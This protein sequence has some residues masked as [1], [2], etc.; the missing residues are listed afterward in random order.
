MV[1]IDSGL[2]WVFCFVLVVLS[3][4]LGRYMRIEG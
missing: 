4:L 3:R 1:A 2:C